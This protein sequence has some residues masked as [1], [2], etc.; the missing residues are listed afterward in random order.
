MGLF[1]PLMRGLF[2][3][4]MGPLSGGGGVTTRSQAASRFGSRADGIVLSFVDD[5]FYAATGYY[6]SAQVKDTATP[7]N[8]YNSHPFGLVTY[9]TPTVKLLRGSNGLYRYQKHNLFLNSG[10][11]VT[12][13][14]GSIVVNAT[15]QVLVTGSGTV[16]LT[17]SGTGV[18]S[19]G[20]PV[21]FTASSVTL[22]CTVAGG[23]TTV[24]V[25]RTPVEAGYVA[26]TAAKRYDLP[27]EWDEFGN[28]LGVLSEQQRINLALWGSDL[29]NAA[30][31][32]TNVTAAKTATGITGVANS[33]TTLTAT[34][35]AGTVLQTITS[36]SA[37][38]LTYCWIKRRTG[39][40]TVEMTQDN[41]ATWAAVTVTSDWTMVSI[42]AATLANPI[43]GLRLGTN[44]DA[45]DVELFQHITGISFTS[46]PIE[47][48]A[49]TATRLGDNM[50]A[51]GV[52]PVSQT[53][54]TI[55]G[56]FEVSRQGLASSRGMD[57]SASTFSNAFYIVSEASSTTFNVFDGTLQ[58]QLVLNGYTAGLF[59]RISGSA[60]PNDFRT[61]QDGVPSTGNPDVSGTFIGAALEKLGIGNRGNSS[62]HLEGH[63]KEAFYF[64]ATSTDDELAALNTPVGSVEKAQSIHLLGDSFLN[65]TGLQL[66]VASALDDKVRSV[67]K[68]GVGGSSL[69]AQKIRFDATPWYYDHIL[70]IMDGGLSDDLATAQAAIQAE[71]AHLTH[72]RW[73]FIEGGYGPGTQ[74]T[75][76]PER[77]V[78]ESIHDW[79]N[80]TY[81]GHFV[82]TLAIMQSYSLG[83]APDLA[84]VAAGLWPTSQTSDGLHPN[85]SGQAHLSQIIADAITAAGW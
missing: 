82:P 45:V 72:D 57:V 61:Y 67:S 15:Y 47:T 19:A 37:L 10:A 73:L 78:I 80:T 41:G 54:G 76:M 26:T 49:V 6:G 85:A 63:V 24:Q 27:F 36:A 81:P 71:I 16:T 58:A 25:V 11:P 56:Q 12:Q 33:A 3:P 8:E 59:T 42:A 69:A 52:F 17:G 22:T 74:E 18:A 5:T 46:S 31:V 70:V 13:S 7:A 20:S 50:V 34:A 39:G 28:L 29:A 55:G 1:Q 35:G 53:E 43:L 64:P 75:G 62:L 83:D 77:L 48:F 79:I 68:D 60:A 4:L 21:S 40:G 38:R 9:A 2:A 23:P 84:A 30:W 32:K 14:I 65:G 44:G 66:Y 51:Q